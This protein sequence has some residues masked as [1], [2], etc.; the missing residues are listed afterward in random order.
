M[1]SY[2][3][4]PR[5]PPQIQTPQIRLPIIAS[6]SSMSTGS[7]RNHFNRRFPVSSNQTKSLTYVLAESK[8]IKY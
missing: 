1:V 6:Y 2:I 4:P 5:P 3:D 7:T 8:L